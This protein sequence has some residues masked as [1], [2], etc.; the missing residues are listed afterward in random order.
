V[1]HP[2][3]RKRSEDDQVGIVKTTDGFVIHVM[4]RYV[5]A[6]DSRQSNEYKV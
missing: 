3:L 1:N 2:A 5:S 4:V 6:S